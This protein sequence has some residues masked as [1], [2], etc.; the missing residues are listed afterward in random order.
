MYPD[1]AICDVL[2]PCAEPNVLQSAVW[3]KVWPTEQHLAAWMA[4]ANSQMAITEVD[5]E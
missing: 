2:V 4:G 5:P 3:R 1:I